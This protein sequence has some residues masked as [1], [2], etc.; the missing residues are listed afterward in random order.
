MG[1]PGW[2]RVGTPEGTEGW[3]PT[4]SAAKGVPH[5]VAQGLEFTDRVRRPLSREGTSTEGRDRG[6]R[7]ATDWRWDS[8]RAGRDERG[9]VINQSSVGR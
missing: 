2:V 6:R 7:C 9:R 4:T 3:Y 5:D 8:D 1:L